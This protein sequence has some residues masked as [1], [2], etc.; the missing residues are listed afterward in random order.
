MVRSSHVAFARQLR[1][2]QTDAERVLLSRL[3]GRQI[4][5]I[6]FRRQQP[7]GE[8]IVDFVSFEKQLIIE[9]DGGQHNTLNNRINDHH[10]AEW[11]ENEGYSVL[12]FW[13]DEVLLHTE[14]V[15]E[16]VYLTLALSSERRGDN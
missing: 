7:I 6:K 16:K 12:R 15:L 10:R 1:H 9:I 11:L 8:Y 5:G 13:N 3:R 14:E 2:N 4:E